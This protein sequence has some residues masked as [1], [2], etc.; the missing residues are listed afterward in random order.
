MKVLIVGGSGQLGKELIFSKPVGIKLFYPTRDELNLASERSCINYIKRNR[1]NFIINCA[2]YTNV[3]KAES[4]KD[5]AFLINSLAPKYLCK[6]INL[7]G[8]NLIQF[9]TDYVFNG[10][11]GNPY[12][13]LDSKNPI[14]YY[15]YT[16]AKGEDFCIENISDIG[17]LNIIRTSWLVG[18][19]RKNFLLTIL[20]LLE[21]K[22]LLEIVSDQIGSP[23]TTNSLAYLCWEIIL[24]KSKSKKFPNIMHLTNR[25]EA[26]WFDLAL[27]IKEIG[28]EMEIFKSSTTLKPI[29]SDEYFTVAKRPLY[30]VLN[31]NS[32]LNYF[33]KVPAYWKDGIKEVLIDINSS[34]LI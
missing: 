20:K 18:K 8:G 32:S 22:D 13:P 6:G 34:N 24:S 2:A 16:K 28:L 7:Y 31:C 12:G 30:S 4:E 1:P 5:L 33:E 23:T 14:N 17:S 15:G 29:R 10:T 25:G 11:K 21:N 3:D 9:S 19:F 27:Y 26:S